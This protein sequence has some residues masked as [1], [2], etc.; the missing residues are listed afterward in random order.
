MMPTSEL[1]FSTLEQL[2]FLTSGGF[3]DRHP[4]RD[5]WRKAHSLGRY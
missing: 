1:G 3:Y 5:H 2:R 4:L